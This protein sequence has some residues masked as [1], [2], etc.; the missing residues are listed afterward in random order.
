[1]FKTKKT[2]SLGSSTLSISIPA[3]LLLS[4]N[5]LA[6]KS[7]ISRNRLIKYAVEDLLKKEGTNT[8][9]SDKNFMISKQALNAHADQ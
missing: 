4:L 6:N 2:Y 1:M 9:H 7:G 3:E 5:D 8:Q